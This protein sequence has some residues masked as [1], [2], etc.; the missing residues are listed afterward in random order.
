MSEGS[1]AG[2]EDQK[3]AAFGSSYTNPVGAAEGCDL[4]FSG[5]LRFRSHLIKRRLIQRISLLIQHLAWMIIA[6]NAAVDQAQQTRPTWRQDEIVA[7]AAFIIR[8]RCNVPAQE[9]QPLIVTGHRF[10]VIQILDRLARTGFLRSIVLGVFSRGETFASTVLH[11]MQQAFNQIPVI[12]R[13]PDSTSGARDL[14]H[15]HRL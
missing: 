9:Q 6:G 7:R 12:S 10:Q 13:H 15:C 8:T 1:K 2:I 5:N 14:G 11:F 3:I 4:L